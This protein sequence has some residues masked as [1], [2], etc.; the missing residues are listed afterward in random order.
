MA[1]V[2]PEDLS[3]AH[4]RAGRALLGFTTKEF[5]HY[6]GGDMSHAKVR[7]IENAKPSGLKT[8]IAMID[9]FERAGIELLNGGRPGA[10]VR[11]AAAYERAVESI[12]TD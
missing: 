9:A 4:V 2:K 11:D 5:A 1:K 3:S 8:R 12:K 7:N 6:A 10:R